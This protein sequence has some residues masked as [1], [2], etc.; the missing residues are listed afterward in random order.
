MSRFFINNEMFGKYAK[1]ST[2]YNNEEF[3]YKV[4]S[5]FESNTYQDV[6]IKCG[7]QPTV[8]D[9]VISVL[10]VVQC[11]IDESKVIRVALKDCLMVSYINNEKE[12]DVYPLA[13]AH[14]TPE[15]TETG[16][17]VL[18][19]K[20][21]TVDALSCSNC[22]MKIDVSEGNFK[23]CPFCGAKMDEEEER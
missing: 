17:V 14:W 9:K 16:V 20:E 23:Y 15:Y 3:I 21:E 19:Y 2:N 10:N 7:D 4:I 8:H 5:L 22:G 12:V 13:H 6:P 18:G 11:G 1:I